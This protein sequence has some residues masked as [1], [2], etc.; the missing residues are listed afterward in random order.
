MTVRLRPH[1]LL[2]MLTYV[3]K[4][5]SEAFTANYDEV[6]KRLVAGDAIELSEGAD[7]VCAPLLGDADPHCL[8]ASVRERDPKAA[9]AVSRLLGRQVKNGDTIEL[10]AALLSTFR[11]EFKKG[12]TRDAC[13]G[14]EWFNLCSDISRTN[15]SGVRLTR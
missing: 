2:C 15:F 11:R 1:H 9:A 10:D 7:D 4:G 12:T 14:C 8:W 5:Y 13:G 3:G 6:I